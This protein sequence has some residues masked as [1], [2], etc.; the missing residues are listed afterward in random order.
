MRCDKTAP[1]QGYTTWSYLRILGDDVLPI[2]Q[3]RLTYQRDGARIHNSKLVKVCF[4][5]P[6]FTLS[7][8][9]YHIVQTRIYWTLLIFFQSSWKAERPGR[10]QGHGFT[11]PL[12]TRCMTG[13]QDSL[14][15]R[16]HDFVTA[17]FS[18]NL[19]WLEPPTTPST[20]DLFLHQ[21]VH[22]WPPAYG[23][24]KFVCTK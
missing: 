16:L 19:S 20:R 18:Y 24:G 4:K 22:F 7:D 10:C 8:T 15:S 14:L 11:K 6:A 9:G 5:V 2:L 17:A 21:D 23:R 13:N 1:K 3:A 12:A